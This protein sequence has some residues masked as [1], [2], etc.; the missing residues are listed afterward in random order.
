MSHKV[1]IDPK[2][3]DDLLDI[4]RFIAEDNP[5]AAAR[6]IG[7]LEDAIASLAT[8]PARVPLRDDLRK[9]YRVMP[10]GAYLIFFRIVGDEVQIMRVLHSARDIAKAFGDANE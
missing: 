8:M 7:V 5:V 4:H 9:G 2:A 3:R 10:V 6:W 1:V